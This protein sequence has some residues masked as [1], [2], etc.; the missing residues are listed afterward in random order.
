MS[1]MERGN[2]GHVHC[3]QGSGAYELNLSDASTS[4]SG[5]PG[6]REAG[7]PQAQAAA[8]QACAVMEGSSDPQI[9]RNRGRQG[10]ERSAELREV[11]VSVTT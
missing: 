10:G 9:E 6:D 5:A 2:E 11:V 4:S 3:L 8:V 1:A 7:R